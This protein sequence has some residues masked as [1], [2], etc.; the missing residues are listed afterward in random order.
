MMSA[1]KSICLESILKERSKQRC[2]AVI[3]SWRSLSTGDGD[4]PGEGGDAPAASGGAG[5]GGDAPAP[6]ES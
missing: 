5:E 1:S 2:L 3:H 4:A 6:M